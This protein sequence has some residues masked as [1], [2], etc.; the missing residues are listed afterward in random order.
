MT[1][2]APLRTEHEF[3]PAAVNATAASDGRSSENTK[4]VTERQT[5]DFAPTLNHSSGNF[6]SENHRRKIAKGI[7]I[8]VQIGAT[9]AAPGDFELDLIDA[10]R[11]VVHVADLHVARTF[12]EFHEVFHILFALI[13]IICTPSSNT[14][15]L[16]EYS[17]ICGSP[18][19][20]STETSPPENVSC[21]LYR[22]SGQAEFF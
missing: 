3:S 22:M 13:M 17:Q 19:V 11:R 1:H 7:V 2:P 21:T 10:A 16:S 6:V 14:G 12:R 20:E 18:A 9:D 15:R 8:N 4:P 5:L